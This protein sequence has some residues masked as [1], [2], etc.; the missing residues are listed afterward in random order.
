MQGCSPAPPYTPLWDSVDLSSHCVVLLSQS[1]AFLSFNS[2]LEKLFHS[3]MI[4]FFVKECLLT[5]FI[6]MWYFLLEYLVFNYFWLNSHVAGSH[7]LLYNVK[8][9]LSLK[10]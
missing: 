4:T 5:Q 7:S 6:Q 1:E 2:S 8:M 3:E 10:P 9:F